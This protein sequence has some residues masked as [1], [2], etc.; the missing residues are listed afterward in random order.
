M[1]RTLPPFST[2][3]SRRPCLRR[4]RIVSGSCLVKFKNHSKS[5]VPRIERISCRTVLSST[6]FVNSSA[7]MSTC[8]VFRCSSPKTN[9]TAR[10]KFGNLYVTNSSGNLLR[11]QI[12]YE[13][14]SISGSDAGA[15]GKLTRSA[16]LSPSNLRYSRVWT[17]CSSLMARTD[18]SSTIKR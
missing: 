6:S 9:C 5:I 14:C 4:S 18:L 12:V 10:T 8:H 11:H 15:V 2:A 13:T 1:H 7:K 3:S 17:R 16:S